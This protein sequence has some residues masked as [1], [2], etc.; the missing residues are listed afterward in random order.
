MKVKSMF[1]AKDSANTWQSYFWIRMHMA[2]A[3]EKLYKLGQWYAQ[4]V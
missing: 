1:W 2:I 3:V 4:Y